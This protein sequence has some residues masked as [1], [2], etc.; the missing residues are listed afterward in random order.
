MSELDN[1]SKAL[2]TVITLKKLSLYIF[3]I[4]ILAFLGGCTGGSI[5]QSSFCIFSSEQE[6][7]TCDPGRLAV[8]QPQVFGN[9]QLPT[10]YAAKYCDFNHQII[11]NDGGFAC[12]FANERPSD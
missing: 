9:K 2:A 8:Y 5:D 4:G 11:Q 10:Y 1:Q 3:G 7:K 12:V 6:A